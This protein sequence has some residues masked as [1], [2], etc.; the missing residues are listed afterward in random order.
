MVVLAVGGQLAHQAAQLLD[1]GLGGA[2]R[3][4]VLAARVAAG[5]AGIQPVLDGAGQQAIGDAT[6]K[7]TSANIA[8]I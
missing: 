6:W 5:L 1:T 3:Q 2:D 4:A 7:K 8:S